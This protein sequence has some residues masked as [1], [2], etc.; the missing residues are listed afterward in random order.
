VRENQLADNSDVAL[1]IGFA[2]RSRIESNVIVQQAQPAFAGLML[3]NFGSDDVS[4]RGDFRDAVITSN[5]VD[6]GEQMCVF[7]IQVGPR[8]WDV[9]R[10][11]LGGDLHQNRVRGAMIGIN[12]DGA[13]T[14]RAPTRIFGNDVDE[15]PVGDYFAG[16]AD[17]IPTGWMNIAPSSAIDRHGESLQA[18]SHLSNPCELAPA[19]AGKAPN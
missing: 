3:H 15:V 14:S 5:T 18:A 11:I 17:R 9:T 4:F 19:S 7:G 12:A 2:A 16:C 6:C 8:P 10:N 13:G 1:I